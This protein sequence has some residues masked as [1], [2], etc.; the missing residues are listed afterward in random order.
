[1]TSQQ[2]VQELSDGYIRLLTETPD[3]LATIREKEKALL[4]CIKDFDGAS[5]PATGKFIYGYI[6]VLNGDFHGIALDSGL[7][8]LEQAHK[9]G[10]LNATVFLSEI[11][12]TS[13][14]VLPDKMKRPLR[15]AVM[16]D[17]AAAKGSVYAKFLIARRLARKTFSSDW[18]KQENDTK[19]LALMQELID[20][21]YCGG[22]YLSAI[23]AS[24]GGPG[25]V[26]M[27]VA[28][29]MLQRAVV[30]W[31]SSDFFMAP[32]ISD[33]KFRLGKLY[34]EGRHIEKNRAEAEKLIR[35]AARG[36]HKD[37][38][39]WLKD[40]NLIELT[41][42]QDNYDS[43]MRF[44]TGKIEKKSLPVS[45]KNSKKDKA[46]KKEADKNSAESTLDDFDTKWAKR[47][48]DA[49]K[50]KLR[51]HYPVGEANADGEE[52]NIESLMAPLD[53]LDGLEAIKK[54]IREIVVYGLTMQRRR[55]EGLAVRS[56]GMHLVLSGN[57]GTGKTMVTRLLG[58]I[59]FRA[60]IL[61]QGHVVEA[62]RT[63]LIGEYIGHT[64]KNVRKACEIADGG[65]LF[66]DEAYS[67]GETP[68]YGQECI[69]SLV[70]IM[71]DEADNFMVVMAGYKSKMDI[72]L[73]TNP[74]LRSRFAKVI[75][76]KDFDLSVLEGIFQKFCRDY[77]YALD[78]FALTKLPLS[79]KAMKSKEKQLFANGRS[80][81]RFFDDVLK[82]QAAR[83]MRD[84]IMDKEGLSVI[85]A[86]DLGAMDERSGSSVVWLNASNSVPD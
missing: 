49:F 55:K 54:Q 37:A 45:N 14:N 50:E 48:L 42:K 20:L 61:A 4:T 12:A 77:D 83:I 3:N 17:E 78:D 33:A 74:G 38:T 84:G 46:E 75:D 8:T 70:K 13:A 19:T 57:P 11:Y 1:M 53:A 27:I 51:I 72:L 43:P 63:G 31:N 67:I 23:W 58:E 79:L 69:D 40:N 15:A 9:E 62:D 73:R 66:I 32:T 24:D 76:F 21:N 28:S 52:Q 60:G 7:E 41:D 85:T 68:Y 64:T 71:E 59:L 2:Q 18:E 30:S 6:A 16:Q 26:S 82:R 5:L 47:E 86:G 22:F 56:L 10:D 29:Q 65:I 35:E 34:D 39:Q 36:G 80:V 25:P 44:F 81:R